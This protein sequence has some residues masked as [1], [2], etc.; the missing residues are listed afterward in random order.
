MS[1]FAGPKNA[2]YSRLDVSHPLGRMTRSN[3]ETGTFYYISSYRLPFDWH[4]ESDMTPPPLAAD[5]AKRLKDCIMDTMSFDPS[6]RPSASDILRTSRS[7]QQDDFGIDESLSIIPIT[8]VKKGMTKELKPI[9][10]LKAQ[11][12][13]IRRY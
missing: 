3:R 10:R 6:K 5:Y 8:I 4:L 11:L 7:Q 9:D 1:S 2:T 12:T 13:G